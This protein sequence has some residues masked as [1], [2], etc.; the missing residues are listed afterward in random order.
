MG[1]P[2]GRSN[3][4]SVNSSREFFID[5]KSSIEDYTHW[6]EIQSKDPNWANQANTE[7]FCVPVSS[8]VEGESN[9]QAW[10]LISLPHM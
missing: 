2:R 7:I 6:M 4:S 10:I 5:F 8:Q 1:H 9:N 3:K